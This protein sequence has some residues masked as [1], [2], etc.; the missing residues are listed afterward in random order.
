MP[1]RFKV[2]SDS[3]SSIDVESMKEIEA[4]IRKVKTRVWNSSQSVPKS[5]QINHKPSVR[6]MN[7]SNFDIER[8]DFILPC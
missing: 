2:S 6:N 7:Q 4:I 8:L 1:D 5:S 3:E